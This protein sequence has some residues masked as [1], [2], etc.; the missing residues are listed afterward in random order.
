[1]GRGRVQREGKGSESQ[2]DTVVQRETDRQADRKTYRQ[3]DRE[4]YRQADRHTDRHTVKNGQAAGKT[5]RNRQGQ[6]E[7]GNRQRDRQK[8]TPCL[9]GLFQFGGQRGEGAL[10]PR[11]AGTLLHHEDHVS[12]GLD[13]VLSSTQLFAA[14][15]RH[16][17]VVGEPAA[18][19]PHNA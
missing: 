15:R 3:A 10:C 17:L 1:M 8:L 2:R 19:C 13:P 9:E 14:A 5:G 4:T 16:R 12:R 6:T 11:V 18:H 7:R